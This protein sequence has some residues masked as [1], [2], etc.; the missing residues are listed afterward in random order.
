M[1]TE[2][3]MTAR[4]AGIILCAVLTLGVT[5]CASDVPP[6][7]TPGPTGTPVPTATP[8]P[9]PTPVPTD[10]G[11]V[12][13]TPLR[14]GFVTDV[15]KI[16]DGTLNQSAWEGIEAAAAEAP[17][18]IAPAHVETATPADYV[19]NI[20][21]FADDD[22][23][24][25]VGIGPFMSDALGDAAAQY[26]NIRFINIDGTPGPGHDQSWSS[27]GTSILF[28]ED[29]A[30]YMAGVLA[31]SLSGSGRIGVVAGPVTVP[32]YERYVEGFANGAR[33]TRPDIAV[34][35]AHLVS[36]AEPLEGYQAAETMTDAG[37]DVIFAAGHLTGNGALLAACDAEKLAIG[38]N[39]DQFLSIVEAQRCLV[40]SALKIVGPAVTGESAPATRTETTATGGIG[41]APFHDHADKVSPEALRL[42]AETFRGLADGSITTGVVVNGSTDG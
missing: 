38:V 40:S 10:G 39:T 19:R 29:E 33:A 9:S 22:Y 23:D 15:G 13:D 11:L 24:I 35:I 5:G 21:R 12:C 16:N 17:T 1:M 2:K 36:I 18:C 37:A 28:A 30:G 14:V 26:R 8:A 32:A 6:S 4:L 27:N 3:T 34:E 42:L 41:L 31:A 25:I 20:A 7:A